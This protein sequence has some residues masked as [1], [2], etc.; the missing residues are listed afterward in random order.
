MHSSTAEC[1]AFCP[2]KPPLAAARPSSFCRAPQGVSNC[3]RG[4]RKRK[5]D[6]GTLL[7]DHRRDC[8]FDAFDGTAAPAVVPAQGGSAC[9]RA[10]AMADRSCC[11]AN[12]HL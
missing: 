12:A 8:S 2:S 7:Q 9:T 4:M 5:L 1:G 10:L 11:A 3:Q 6:S